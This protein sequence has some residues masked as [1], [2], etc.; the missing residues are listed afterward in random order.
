MKKNFKV[1][2]RVVIVKTGSAAL[3]NVT[4]I[5]LGKSFINV[6]DHYIVLLDEEFVKNTDLLDYVMPGAKALC[7]TE[8]CL[9]LID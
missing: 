2:D 1:D 8:S 5:I 6:I 3:D 4:G 9:E 7:I